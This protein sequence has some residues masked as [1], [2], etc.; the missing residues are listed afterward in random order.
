M[1]D[2]K[3][4]VLGLD[5]ATWTLLDK[6]IEEGH[7]PNLGKLRKEGVSG[8][9]K[10]VIPPF[11]CPSWKSYS[12]GR[13]PANLGAFGWG[14]ADWE[15]EE[16]VSTRS[17]TYFEDKELWDYLNQTGYRTGIINMPTTYPPKKVDGYMI[18]GPTTPDENKDYTYPP[19][20]KEKLESKYDYEIFS[21]TPLGL[22]DVLGEEKMIN[23]IK[24]VVRTRFEVAK[25]FFQDIDFLH[26]TLYYTD[27]LQHVF[28]DSR[29]VREVWKTIDQEIGKLLD[30]YPEANLFIISDHGFEKIDT[31]FNLSNWLRSKGYF[32]TKEKSSGS[33]LK[34]IGITRENILKIAR[35]LNFGRIMKKILK[36]FPE[37]SEKI[38]SA[39][40]REFSEERKR[41]W[42]RSNVIPLMS[43]LI[44]IN[45]KLSDKENF[46][47]TLKKEILN[48]RNPETG[49]KIV[50]KIL[51]KKD[52]FQGKYSNIA[53][54]LAVVPKANVYIHSKMVK[55]IWGKNIEWIAAHNLEGVFM[56][57]GP[58]IGERKVNNANLIDVSPTI[59]HLFDIPI[60]KSLDGKVLKDIFK[61]G[62]DAS[63]RSIEYKKY[64]EKENIRSKIRTLKNQG[65]I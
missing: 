57:Y 14:H 22:R 35:N 18:C 43:N 16:V 20:L 19:D 51:E 10:S 56:A 50:D 6:Y 3:V 38:D 12:T 34:N 65:E 15:K 60:P 29:P 21:D 64:S 37:F 28:W 17:S 61:K 41:D 8:N 48:I 23:S 55:G 13:K 49:E 11:T 33:F 54:D 42:K 27:S 26:L 30:E 36:K 46:K 63:E 24:D 2:S 52:I 9:L 40:P 5:G 32:K 39:V 58:D 31:Y 62:T 44:Y 7:L 59:L 25:D 4:I 53:P 1:I 47:D 45:P